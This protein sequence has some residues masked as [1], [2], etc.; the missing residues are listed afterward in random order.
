MPIFNDMTNKEAAKVLND[1]STVNR[2][3]SLPYIN[4]AIHA[5][6]KAL[7]Q[8]DNIKAQNAE[9]KTRLGIDETVV[10]KDAD[11]K[12]EI[13]WYEWQEAPDVTWSSGS[14][15]KLYGCMK[16]RGGEVYRITKT[17]Y[18][19]CVSI[20]REKWD[21]K[22]CCCVSSDDERKGNEKVPKNKDRTMGRFSVVEYGLY[23][24]YIQT[25]T[26]AI[27]R[28]GVTE[29]DL[30]LLI[31][32]ILHMFDDDMSS[33]RPSMTVR[34]VVVVRQNRNSGRVRPTDIEDAMVAKLKPGV[35]NPTS[36]NDYDLEFKRDML[37]D[38]VEVKEYTMDNPEGV[39]L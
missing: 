7:D 39:I 1:Y 14:F 31:Q 28:N 2:N 18:G 35:N 13:V 15:T 20:K 23:H 6:I 21:D 16:Q 29:D 11:T 12:V 17:I 24:M 33:V 27:L 25:S 10:P 19:K 9:Y 8:I 32:T 34:K 3:A 37:P 26:K 36:F 22:H 4:E 30:K 5:A 38:S